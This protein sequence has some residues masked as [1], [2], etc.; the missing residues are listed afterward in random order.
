M[1]L[2]RPTIAAQTKILP[3]LHRSFL[4]PRDRSATLQ[5]FGP[6]AA[7]LYSDAPVQTGRNSRR[8]TSDGHIRARSSVG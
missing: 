7:G 4:P 3:R 2:R 5:E 8:T 1:A 6:A